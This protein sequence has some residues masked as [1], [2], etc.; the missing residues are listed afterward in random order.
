MP[1]SS[2]N[3]KCDGTIF[4]SGFGWRLKPFAE[5]QKSPFFVSNSSR[6]IIVKYSLVKPPI[7]E[8]WIIL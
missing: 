7:E 6:I 2:K 8:L 5:I 4:E 3:F 1:A